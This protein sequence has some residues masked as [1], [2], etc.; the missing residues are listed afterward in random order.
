MKVVLQRVASARVEIFE[1]AHDPAPYV[2]RSIE[3][4]FAVLLGVAQGDTTMAADKLI[5]KMTGLRVFADAEAKM[6]LDI[7]Q[8]AGSFLIVSQF[9]LLS[10][11]RKGRRPSF[12]RAAD[13][14]IGEEL[15]RY[16]VDR[17]RAHG[18]TVETGEFGAHMLVHIVNDGPV[19]I[20]LDTDHM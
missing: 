7:R 6:N 12:I 8:A 14:T 15:Y 11:T 17:L 19:T 10:D 1:D 5:D 4:G 20:L 2:V 16:M 18:F 13:P 3:R 9:T